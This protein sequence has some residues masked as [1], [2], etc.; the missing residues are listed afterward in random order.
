[1]LE[2]VTLF[3]AQV[4]RVL[5]ADTVSAC[6][7]TARR[8]GAA[9][10]GCFERYDVLLMPTLGRVPVPL[11]QTEPTPN[12]QRLLRFLVTPAAAGLFRVPQVRE[13]LVDTQL[14]TLAHR[15]RPRTMVANLTGIPAMS[16]PLHRTE[17]DLP[18]GVQFLA[19]YGGEAGLLRLAA[20]LE[21]AKPWRVRH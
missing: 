16:M 17:N 8:V 13:R 20:Q 14:E 15:V 9:L 7:L 19:P 18:I 2:E 10:A 1:L 5:S 11:A 3:L 4:G 6:H 21:R 12:E